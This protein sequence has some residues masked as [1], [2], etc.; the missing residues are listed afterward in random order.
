MSHPL[1][2]EAVTT[3]LPCFLAPRAV[4]QLKVPK[5]QKGGLEGLELAVFR[6]QSTTKRLVFSE[7]HNLDADPAN[8][9]FL[10]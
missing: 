4:Q 10:F 3:G 1:S 6:A 7:P 2:S 8:H 5:V 9:I